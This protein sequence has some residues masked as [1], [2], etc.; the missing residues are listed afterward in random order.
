MAT[1]LNIV[2]K[3]YP[4]VESVTDAP[5]ALR[6]EVKRI[7]S[8][9]AAVK[10]HKGCAMSVACKRTFHVDG[11]VIS[12]DRAYL[13]KGNRA[14]RYALPKSVS[15]EVVS[16]DRGGG[17]AEGVY[18]LIKPPAHVTSNPKA[19]KRI[20]DQNSPGYKPRFVHQT[21]GIRESLVNKDAA[22]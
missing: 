1:S 17:F 4:E 21:T 13:V 11:V 5:K 12:R 8:N 7:D 9:S 10:N 19:K 2:R 20:G 3:F 18:E 15:R 14:T 16:F 22:A 6:V